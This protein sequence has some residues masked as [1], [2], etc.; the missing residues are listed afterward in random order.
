MPYQNTIFVDHT[1]IAV[2]LILAYSIYLLIKNKTFHFSDTFSIIFLW[3]LTPHILDTLYSG[4]KSNARHL[5]LDSSSLMFKLG[6]KGHLTQWWRPAL[7]TENK[8]IFT[9]VGIRFRF[10]L[11]TFFA[12]MILL[13]PWLTW[14]TEAKTVTLVQERWRC[15]LQKA[16]NSRLYHI[17][18]LLKK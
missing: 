9:K 18:I 10:F 17:S 3:V 8:W 6:H 1:L 12:N 13:N 16:E 4:V 7:I 11:H 15:W 2:H 14:Q 5:C